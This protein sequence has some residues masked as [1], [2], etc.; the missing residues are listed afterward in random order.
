MATRLSLACDGDEERT[1]Q[2]EGYGKLCG[3][4]RADVLVK[5][6]ACLLDQ[7]QGS[8]RTF[9]SPGGADACLS[10]IQSDFEVWRALA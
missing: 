7:S 4:E 10:G 9:S 5:G 8:C 6:M 1:R 2:I 3:R